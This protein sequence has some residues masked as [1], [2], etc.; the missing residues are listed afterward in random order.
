MFPTEQSGGYIN[1]KPLNATGVI[2]AR[3]S[4]VFVNIGTNWLNINGNEV[5]MNQ[6]SY[7]L[8]QYGSCVIQVNT[9]D[10]HGPNP[11]NIV[12]FSL[13]MSNVQYTLTAIAGSGGTIS[14]SGNVTVNQGE[15]KTFTATPDNGKMIDEWKV[16]GNVVASSGNTYT[17]SN[18][19]ANATIQV[20]FK[21]IPSVTFTLTALAG[22]GGIIS[23]NGS[24]IVKQGESKTFTATPDNGK[25][26][27][28]WKVDGNVV[29]SA[30]NTYTVS[31][32]Q[33]NATVQVT[34]KDIPPVTTYTL[35][36]NSG[37]GSGNYEVGAVVTIEANTAPSGK[38][39][40]KWTGD[41]SG[42]ADV[43]VA[44]TTYKMGNANATITATYKDGSQDYSWLTQP[45][46]EFIVTGNSV[47]VKAVG[48]T[49]ETFNKVTINGV[50]I[51]QIGGKWSIDTSSGDIWKVKMTNNVNVILS[52]T[53][54]K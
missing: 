15:S 23:P 14:P 33:A 36:V 52:K 11:T 31:N 6:T 28:Q 49:A 2:E 46:I 32:V 27:D 34:F 17:V 16:D 13:T 20:T 25:M 53:Y 9:R 37:K 12:N 44:N 40:D 39:F 30:G 29:A 47:E 43:N 4:N 10:G 19:Q 24:V 26:V 5:A 41:V 42:I 45:T 22:S 7:N 48:P 35:T 50:E 51:P 21:D 3:V 54:K 8:S 18:V 38:T 1:L